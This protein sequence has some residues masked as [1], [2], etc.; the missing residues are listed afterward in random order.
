MDLQRAWGSE[1]V[2]PAKE[3]FL[4]VTNDLR[5]KIKSRIQWLDLSLR[6]GKDLRVWSKILRIKEWDF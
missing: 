6:T 4:K 3:K 5:V 1:T 2:F